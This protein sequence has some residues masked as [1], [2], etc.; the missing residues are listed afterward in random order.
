MGPLGE[1]ILNAATLGDA[2]RSLCRYFPAIQEHST[3]RLRA[4]EGLLALEYQIRDGRIA[5]RR[6]DAELTIGMFAQI[7]T[8][9]CGAGWGAEEIH[10]EHL[11]GDD[12]A[13]IRAVLHAPVYFGAP[14]NAILFRRDALETPMPGAN[15]ARLPAL[16]AALNASLAIARPDD[17]IGGVVQEIRQGF[18]RGAAGIDDVAARLGFSRAALYRRLAAEGTDFSTLT[19]QARKSLA[20]IYVSQPGIAFTDIAPLLGYSELSAFSRA[21]TRWTG[22]SPARYRTRRAAQPESAARCS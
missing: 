16:Q 20:I 13:G 3:M 19:E 5:Q 12:A 4:T 21:F 8:R 6:Q 22:L 11:R 15:P 2:L 14:S 17:F 7:F 10:F 1:L 18:G 9:A